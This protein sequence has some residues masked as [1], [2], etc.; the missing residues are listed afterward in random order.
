MNKTYFQLAGIMVAATILFS[1]CSNN[2]E[3]IPQD[4]EGKETYLADK[5]SELRDLQLTIEKLEKEIKSLKSDDKKDP[6]GVNTY[7]LEPEEFKRYQEVQASV[8]ADDMVNVSSDIGG[9][10]IRVYVDEGD[11]VKRG[12]LIAV[13]DMQTLEKQLEEIKTSLELA[14]IVYERQKRLWDQNI[15]SEIQFLEAKNN[16][17]RLERSLETLQSQ[18]DKKNIYSPISGIVD[19]EFLDSGEIAS[20]GMPIVRILNPNKVKIV[21]DLQE[22]LLGKVKKGDEVEIYFPSLD[23]SMKKKITMIGRTIDESN[24]TF[25]IEIATDSQNGMLKPNLLGKVI[26]ND[27][28]KQDALVIPLQALRE[29]VDSRKYV[30]TVETEN[31]SKVAS[32]SYITLGE[33]SDG[34]AVV[35]EGVENG[36]SVIIASTGALSDGYPVTVNSSSSTINE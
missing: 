13:T 15:G 26:I 10:L 25:K 21:A 28:S 16:K 30:F 24:R 8:Q 19:M 20:P 35:E 11:Y 32:K 12:Q 17:E 36:D 33:S 22:S 4:L 31:D 18:V 9:R 23:K 6:I 27:Y 14:N 34:Y 5:K 3:E 1:A 2:G 7:V 29:G